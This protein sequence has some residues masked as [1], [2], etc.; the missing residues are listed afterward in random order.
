MKNLYLTVEGQ[1]EE[2]FALKLLHP[3]LTAFNVF[4]WPPR[5]TGPHGRRHGRI[6]QGGMFNTFRHALE[7]MRRWLKEN[8]SADARFS[9]MVD[10]YHLPHDFPGYDQAMALADCFQQAA[11]LETTLATELA[12]PRFIPYLQVH[13][14][15][16]LVLSVPAQF[17]DWFE[18][19]QHALAGLAAECQPFETPERIDHGQHYHPKARIKRHFEDYDENV[20]GP[21][22]AHAIG[23]PTIRQRCPH[24]DQWFTRLEQ[25]DAAGA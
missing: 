2:D 25:L 7:D 19:R 18:D 8:H 10:I 22:L 15:E 17:A 14:F 24:F 23:L 12:D 6:P 9:M 1:T 4:L 20:H 21:L 3:H 11:A 5:F 13:E 16:A